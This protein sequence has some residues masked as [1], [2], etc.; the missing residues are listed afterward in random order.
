MSVP[1]RNVSEVEDPIGQHVGQSPTPGGLRPAWYIRPVSEGRRNYSDDEVEE[2][3]RRA[4]ER[5][6]A[7]GDG[8]AHDELIAAAHE[9]GLDDDAIERAVR[10]LEHDRTEESI[11]AAV[12]R[13]KRERW[14]R[15]LVTYLVI[16]GGFLGMHALGY[17]GVWAIWMAFGWGMG[18][19][20]QTFGAL[21]GATEEEVDKERKKLNRKA[22][23]AAQAKARAEAKRRK[24]EEKARRAK[25]SHHRSQIE[26]DL[27]RVIEDGVSLLLSAAAKKLREATERAEPAPPRTDFER[28]VRAKREGRAADVHAKERPRVRVEDAAKEEARAP[29]GEPEETEARSRRR[30]RRR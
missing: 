21:R 24:A 29:E 15:H 3:F 5:Q 9:V 25:R 1:E 7:A 26:D 10:E 8:F 12:T 4:L 19:A 20:L 28:Y 17:V 2:I 6:A 18:V 13:K 14:L 16:A 11:R 27:E 30:R 23:R 22:R